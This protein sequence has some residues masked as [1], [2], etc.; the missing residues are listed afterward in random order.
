MNR[1]SLDGRV[2]LVTGASAGIGKALAIGF[3]ASGAK[4]IAVA[5]NTAALEAISLQSPGSILACPC[6]LTNPS[7]IAALADVVARYGRLDILAHSAG[8]LGAI[9]EVAQLDPGAWRQAIDLNIT[10]TFDLLRAL[11]PWLRRAPAG[12][13]LFLTSAAAT[14]FNPGWSAYSASKAGFEALVRIYALEAATSPLRC[15]LVD[16]GPMRTQI[17]AQAFPDEDPSRLPN[18]SA[19]VPMM[20]DLARDDRE[21]PTDIAFRA[22]SATRA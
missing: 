15:V 6:D 22:W 7:H 18:A 14:A 5:R 21:P 2:A 17:R 9:G 10:G 8:V 16:P 4:V 11:D 19:I 1:E 13:A 20:L 3:A 12:R